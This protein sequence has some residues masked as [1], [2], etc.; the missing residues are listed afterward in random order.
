MDANKKIEELFNK[1]V[2]TNEIKD[3]S[4]AVEFQLLYQNFLQ[5]TDN[6]PVTKQY[7]GRKIGKILY[8]KQDRKTLKQIYFIDKACLNTA[9]E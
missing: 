4:K 3:G 7:F 9:G 5:F 1:W 6:I 2:T 8:R